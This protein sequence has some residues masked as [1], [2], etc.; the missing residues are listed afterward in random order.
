MTATVR[1][2]LKKVTLQAARSKEFPEGSMRHGYEFLA[3]LTESG[4]ID[5][6]AWKARRSECFVHRFWGD[7]PPQRGLLAHRPGGPGGS[8]WSFEYETAA[9]RGDEE[10][11]YRFGDHVFRVGEYVS[12]REDGQLMPFKVV[13]VA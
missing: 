6:E 3:P 12:I 13:E 4:R 9:Y 1:S 5:V 11:G 2:A 10:A 7:E 8:T